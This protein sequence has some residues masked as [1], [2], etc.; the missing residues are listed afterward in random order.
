[1]ASETTHNDA[2]LRMLFALQRLPPSLVSAILEDQELVTR[3]EVPKTPRRLQLSTTEW[4]ERDALLMAFQMAADAAAGAA[5]VNIR[6]GDQS[7]EA[8]VRV[9]QDG[10]GILEAQTLRIRYAHV[11]LWLTDVRRRREVLAQILRQHTLSEKFR[12]EL[13]KLVHVPH[14]GPE[15]LVEASQIL[16]ASPEE[17]L[18]RLSS[19][20][21]TKTQFDE[22]D[23]LPEDERHWDNITAAPNHST[24][25]AQF[26]EDELLVERKERLSDDPVGA[27]EM[28]SLQFSAQESVPHDWFSRLD[29]DVLLQ[30]VEQA[31][32][33]EDPFG[34]V[35]AFEICARN[36]VRDPRLVG[37]GDRL[38]ERLFSDT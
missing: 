9:D 29:K 35:G 3:F 24:T 21:S 10:N 32:Q 14:F 19:V 16:N 26:I 1:M 22:G 36:V 18:H 12:G 4:V 15:T 37:I 31:L 5:S 27:F 20:A 17:F 25:L 7:R 6:D 34:L 11:G 8:V 38:L 28:L 2:L 13:T 23:F 30:C 33:F